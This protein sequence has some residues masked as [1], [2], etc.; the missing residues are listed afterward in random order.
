MKLVK[1]DLR[2]ARTGANIK[3]G[4]HD[5]SGNTM[6][7]TPSVVIA[8]QFQPV[9]LDLSSIADASKKTIDAIVVTVV[10]ADTD[11]TVY[12]D[13]LVAQKCGN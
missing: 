9:T 5:A 4:L 2:A 13:N 10:N 11:N 6:E 8:N 1:F 7:I 12:L 3:I